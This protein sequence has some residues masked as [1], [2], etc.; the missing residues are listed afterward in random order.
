[1]MMLISTILLSCSTVAPAE[2][3]PV[4]LELDFPLFPDPFDLE[5]EPL[6]RLEVGR[7]WMPLNYWLRITEYQ[8]E[9]EVTRQEYES[10]RE[11]YFEEEQ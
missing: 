6:V 7:V 5:G 11:I 2:I 9:V 1:M 3:K 8:I 4:P 10:W